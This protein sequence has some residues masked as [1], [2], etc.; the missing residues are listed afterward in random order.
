MDIPDIG[1]H[2]D[3]YQGSFKDHPER[4]HFVLNPREFELAF[5]D[6]GD[7]MIISKTGQYK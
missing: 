3:R 4:V 5:P 7:R 6:R 1:R 2:H